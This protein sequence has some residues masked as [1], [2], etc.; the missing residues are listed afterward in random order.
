MLHWKTK[1]VVLAVT[2]A[3]LASVLASV[4]HA[5]GFAW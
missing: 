3:S 5:A 2:A 4:R 1:L